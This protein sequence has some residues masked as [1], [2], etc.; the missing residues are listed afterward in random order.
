M[1]IYLCIQ[2]HC[3][4]TL[5]TAYCYRS[6]VQDS[7]V[8]YTGTNM[9]KRLTGKNGEQS[10]VCLQSHVVLCQLE[11]SGVGGGLHQWVCSPAGQTVGGHEWVEWRERRQ[12]WSVCEVWGVGGVGRKVVI[13]FHMQP[14]TQD[15][16]ANATPTHT[17]VRVHTQKFVIPFHML[18]M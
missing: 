6:L 17:R 12:G 15:M 7:R 3:I 11:W 10:Y 9:Y 2:T 16:S 18:L 1:P 8:Y 13:P 14:H 4:S 5:Y